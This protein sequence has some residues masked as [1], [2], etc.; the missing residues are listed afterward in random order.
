MRTPTSRGRPAISTWASG[1]FDVFVLG[2]DLKLYWKKTDNNGAS[3]TAWTS[4]GG[5][6]A[7]APQAVSWGPNRIDVFA[8]SSG[9]TLVHIF[10]NNGTW[11]AWET[12][13]NDITS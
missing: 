6:L 7:A 5:S 8:R 11:S 9:S 12:L 10:Y 1:H 13:V 2:G 4:L 3:W